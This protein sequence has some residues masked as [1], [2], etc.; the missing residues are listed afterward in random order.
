M[1][2]SNAGSVPVVFEADRPSL[3]LGLGARAEA[4]ADEILSLID[5]CLASLGHDRSAISLLVTHQRRMSHPGLNAVAQRLG[6]SLVAADETA[7]A[8]EVPNPSKGVHAHI[9]MA[10][11]A[12]AAAQ[13]L[14]PLIGEKAR[15]QNATCAIARL[16]LPYGVISAMASTTASTLSTSRAAP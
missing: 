10:S 14:G 4:G 3:V 16:D 8:A 11:I 5:R 1:S 6:V 2:D 15:S 12:E 13:S 9:G 7:F